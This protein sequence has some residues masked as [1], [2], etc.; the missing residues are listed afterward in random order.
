MGYSSIK[1]KMAV[2]GSP[3]KTAKPK[4]KV[5]DDIEGHMPSEDGTEDAGY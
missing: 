3:K 2:P 4:K 5:F 1:T